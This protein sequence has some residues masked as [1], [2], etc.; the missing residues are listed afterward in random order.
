VKVSVLIATYGD[1]QWETLA[2][3]RALPTAQTQ[4]AFEILLRHEPDGTVT[5]SRNALAD[6]AR[7]DWL[8]Y[9]DADDELAPGYLGA[10]R[11]AFEQET[12]RPRARRQLLLTPAQRPAMARRGTARRGVAAQGRAWLLTPRVSYVRK[13]R[14]SAPRHLDRGIPLTDDNWLVVGTLIQRD[15]FLEVGGFGDYPHGFEDWSLWAKAWK[16]GAEIVKVDDAVYRAHWNPNS[17]H[18]LQWKDRRW[19]VDMHN[20]VRRELF[21]ELA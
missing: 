18:R 7:G 12:R 5:T 2:R 21:P 20:R 4:D 9:L 11:R 19:Q 16:A 6:Q 17:K 8:C 1:P 3:S 13:G 10:M 14:A 15:L